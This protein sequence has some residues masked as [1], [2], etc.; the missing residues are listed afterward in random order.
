[1]LLTSRL[2]ASLFLLVSSTAPLL[3]C[4]SSSSWGSSSESGGGSYTGGGSYGGSDAGSGTEAS[5]CTRRTLTDPP[6]SGASDDDVADSKAADFDGDGHV[7]LVVADA[8][9]YRIYLN[10]AGGAL[11]PLERVAVGRMGLTAVR[12][13]DFDADGHVDLVLVG[14]SVIGLGL[15]VG[16]GTFGEVTWTRTTA[17]PL[18]AAAVDLDGDPRADLVARIETKVVAYENVQG[19]LTEKHSTYVGSVDIAVGDF[20][21][22]KHVDVAVLDSSDHVLLY[23]GDGVGAFVRHGSL[24]TLNPGSYIFAHDLDGDGHLD[25]VTY[26]NGKLVTVLGRGDFTFG[27]ELYSQTSEVGHEILF[28]DVDGDGHDDVAGGSASSQHLV[29]LLG[30]G[31]GTVQTP[32]SYSLP[33]YAFTLTALTAA[34]FDEDG[35]SDVVIM[36]DGAVSILMHGCR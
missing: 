36:D 30:N 11:A 15:G 25:L 4:S 26:D 33:P 14:S 21:E 31:L 17:T 22:D 6:T 29:V 2:R 19:K 34:D 18:F 13:G 23:R 32:R 8:S 7:D 9:G 10:D 27:E 28:A 35:K 5:E 1:M 24:A 3:A 20:D 12:L 16:D